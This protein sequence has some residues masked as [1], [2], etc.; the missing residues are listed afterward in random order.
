[1]VANY[2]F[3]DMPV[4]VFFNKKALIIDETLVGE[5]KKIRKWICKFAILKNAWLPRLNFSL[6][7]KSTQIGFSRALKLIPSF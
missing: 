4:A 3:K 6:D 1:M 5:W 2:N 7:K